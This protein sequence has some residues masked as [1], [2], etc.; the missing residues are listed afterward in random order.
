MSAVFAIWAPFVCRR[1]GTVA[2]AA[3]LI[4]PRVGCTPSDVE[5]GIRILKCLLQAEARLDDLQSCG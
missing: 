1:T 3:H 4:G 5:P 2:I